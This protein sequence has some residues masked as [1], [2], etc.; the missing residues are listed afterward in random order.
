LSG[1]SGRKK[2]EQERGNGGRMRGREGRN[3]EGAGGEEK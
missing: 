2:Q 3:K 1:S